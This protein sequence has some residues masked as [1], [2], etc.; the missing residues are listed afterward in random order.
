MV[1]RQAP[2]TC[3]W[4]FNPSMEVVS[5]PT[6]VDGT[7]YAGGG[8][9]LEN[10]QLY[11]VDR[12]TGSEKWRT[13]NN[14][15]GFVDKGSPAVWSDYVFIAFRDGIYSFDRNT[16]D[17]KWRLEMDDWGLGSSYATQPTVSD[18]TVYFVDKNSIIAIDAQTG[19]KQWSGTI[20]AP[21]EASTPP[22]VCENAIY[23]NSHEVNTHLE[24]PDCG[25][26]SAIDKNSGEIMWKIRTHRYHSSDPIVSDGKVYIE[27]H[28]FGSDTIHIKIS[29]ISSSKEDLIE[30]PASLGPRAETPWTKFEESLYIVTKNSLRSVNVGSGTEQWTFEMGDGTASRP[31]VANNVVYIG[32]GEYL[33]AIDINTGQKKW[34]FRTEG[35]V[36]SPIVVDGS[37]YITDGSSL[38]AINVEGSAWSEDAQVLLGS[39]NHHNYRTTGDPADYSIGDQSDTMVFQPDTDDTKVYNENT[40]DEAICPDCGTIVSEAN[41]HYCGHCGSKL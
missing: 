6:A 33:H 37:V 12:S 29:D 31:T 7:V 1:S 15:S 34:D 17:Q 13:T 4:R 40:T 41:A 8:E 30:Y 39:S 19:I 10:G 21:G 24:V 26:L 11:A 23:V 2:G 3:L 36:Q 35:N 27:E 9:T 14:D 5:P 28:G 16:G 20:P 25:F 18:G 32:D 22:V 38:Y